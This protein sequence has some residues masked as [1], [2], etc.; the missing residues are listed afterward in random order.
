MIESVKMV[1]KPK[2]AKTVPMIYDWYLEGEGIRSIQ[3]KLE[4]SGRLTA[5]GKT[6]WHVTNISRILKNTLYCGFIT[7]HKH[8]MPDYL[9]RKN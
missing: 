9:E 2:Q 1:I 5:M 6:T 4:Q 7:Y 3:F 8:R